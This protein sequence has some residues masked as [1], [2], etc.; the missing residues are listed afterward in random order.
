MHLVG[1]YTYCRMMQGAYSV[2][3]FSNTFA[4]LASVEVNRPKADYRI[5]LKNMAVSNVIMSY[6]IQRLNCRLDEICF[7]CREK[8]DNLVL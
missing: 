1:L 2:K 3:L 8:V 4:C 6:R 5:W 7:A